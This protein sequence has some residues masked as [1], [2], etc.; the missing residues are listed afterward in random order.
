[1]NS[2]LNKLDI[3]C[4]NKTGKKGSIKKETPKVFK[5]IF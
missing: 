1:M 4:E 5:A 3:K 2:L